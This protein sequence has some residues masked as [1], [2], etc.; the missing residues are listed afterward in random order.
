MKLNEYQEIA[1]RTAIYPRDGIT[2]LLYTALGLGE[3]GE[4]QGKVSKILRDDKGVLADER[5]KDLI[6]ELG[7][8][9]WYVATC[10]RELNVSLEDVCKNNVAKLGDRKK[11]NK[12]SGSGDKR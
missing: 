10:A 7:D 12:L 4:F 6:D 8:I 2:G 5:R 11:R 1:L 3:A 9:M